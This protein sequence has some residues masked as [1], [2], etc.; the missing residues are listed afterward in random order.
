MSDYDIFDL[1]FHWKKWNGQCKRDG[2]PVFQPIG[3]RSLAVKY[4]ERDVHS[5]V[6]TATADALATADLFDVYKTI[7]NSDLANRVHEPGIAEFQ[8]IKTVKNKIQSW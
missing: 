2:K 5:G 3:L 1:H 4:L 7:K 8:N 6:H